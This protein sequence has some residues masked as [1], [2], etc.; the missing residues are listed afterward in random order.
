ML[1]FAL[2][3]FAS[4]AQTG[5]PAVTRTSMV[6]A[7]RRLNDETAARA[8]AIC[9]YESSNDRWGCDP[10]GLAQFTLD[11]EASTQSGVVDATFRLLADPVDPSCVAGVD[12]TLLS[13]EALEIDWPRATA[14][15]NGDIV[16]LL[17]DATRAKG[18]R[19]TRAMSE[20]GVPVHDVVRPHA[21]SGACVL[22]AVPARGV[23][24]DV[25]ELRIPLVVAGKATTVTWTRKAEWRGVDERTALEAL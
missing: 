4:I 6:P 3:A 17:T 15:A 21:G 20:P 2:I 11:V 9:G 18:A 10:I 14:T 12:V 7:P 1:S 16:V 5:E 22:R 19:A 8:A 23:P 13:P 25:F 24:S